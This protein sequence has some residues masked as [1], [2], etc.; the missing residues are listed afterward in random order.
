[1]KK[2]I[3]IVAAAVLAFV[4]FNFSTQAVTVKNKKAKPPVGELLRDGDIV[5]QST[6]SMQCNAV[7]MATHSPYSH[8]GIV[9]KENNKVYVYEAVQP[10]KKTLLEEWIKQ[11]KSGKFDVKR[12]KKSDSLL[13]ASVLQKMKIYATGFIGK[14][15]DLY[16]E[17]T[18]ERIY[19]SEYVWK[20]YKNA[21]NIEVGKLKQLKDFDL[22][23]T[24]VKQ[25]L[26]ERYGNSIPYNETVISPADIFKSELLV[27]VQL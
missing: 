22:T 5:F 18:D 2:L 21:A 7:Q 25:I 26:K 4:I 20:I 10:V 23:S 13:P 6:A 24:E 3:T 1:M 15:Y 8:C 12:L 14:K 9:F 11:G 27:G 16:F 17:W 19:C